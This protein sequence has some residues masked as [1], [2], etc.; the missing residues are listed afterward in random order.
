MFVATV[1]C[2]LNFQQ[3]FLIDI[4]TTIH[5]ANTTNCYLCK[6]SEEWRKS[7]LDSI[8]IE[9]CSIIF[10][11]WKIVIPNT[12]RVT[13]CIRNR[14]S[15]FGQVN[16]QR[17]KRASGL[18][19]EIQIVTDSPY[20]N[21]PPRPASRMRFTAPSSDSERS[22]SPIPAG[23]QCASETKSP[24]LAK[25][26]GQREKRASGLHEEIQIVTDS[27]Y[28]NLP[29]QPA[30]RMRFTASSSDSERSSSPIPRTISIRKGVSTFCQTMYTASEAG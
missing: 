27:P 11:F 13:M 7:D 14:V 21:L 20:P 26:H 10:R 5:K 8:K 1:V 23:S 6:F 17:E 22:L 3:W 16:R 24:P 18:H 19:E 25:S 28:P 2:N 12:S 30:S 15:T 29:P 4:V 9:S